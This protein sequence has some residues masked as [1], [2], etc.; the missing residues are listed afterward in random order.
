MLR[1]RG[2][3]DGPA[4]FAFIAA[5]P[6]PFRRPWRRTARRALI[7]AVRLTGKKECAATAAAGALL[8]LVGLGHA[9][10]ASP[11]FE[12]LANFR[13]HLAVLAGIVGLVA[14]LRRWRLGAGLALGAA[15]L[16]VA[17]LGPA[18][19]TAERPG[20]GFAVTLLYANLRDDN[21]ETAALIRAL[22]GADADILVTSETMP[23]VAKALAALYPHAVVAGEGASR[24]TA[25]WSR[26]PLTGGQLFRNNTV[27]PT[28]ATARAELWDDR[29]LS[30]I[31]AHFSRP[32]EGLH[33]RQADAL[34]TMAARLGAPLVVAGDFNAAPWSR[35]VRRAAAAS[36]TGVL[37]G[38]RVTWRGAY[39]TPL[40]PLPAPWGQ[41]ID[42]IL[43][44]P[45][46]GVEAVRTVALPGSD[47]RGVM[48]RL[49]VP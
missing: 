25:I 19:E 29:R 10:G 43:L 4:P 3:A 24:R 47:H 5:I 40:G 12:V 15:T 41:Q 9:P 14:L 49:R 33:M 46:F 18:L 42:Q 48:V 34:G 8:L 23:P 28:A 17:G 1:G 21:A 44:S 36:G 37:G 22:A 16:A 13:L 35:L 7:T 20:R 31:G 27:A 11:W 32:F 2:P 39:P 45:G 38:Y 26:F 30:I 6:P